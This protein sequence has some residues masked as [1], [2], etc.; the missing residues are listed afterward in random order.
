MFLFWG[1]PI[2]VLGIYKHKVGYPQEGVWYD[3][4][5]SLGSDLG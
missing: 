4:T 2:L 5:G 1:Y 3:P